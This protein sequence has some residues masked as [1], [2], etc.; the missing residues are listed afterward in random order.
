M[1]A[2]RINP[3][4][5]SSIATGL[6]PTAK[7]A[8][9]AVSGFL[10]SM[11]Q[12]RQEEME[13]ERQ[14]QKLLTLNAYERG[15]SNVD[16]T[17]EQ[18]AD[19][20]SGMLQ[21]GTEQKIDF[22][23]EDISDLRTRSKETRESLTEEKER[24]NVIKAA[25]AAATKQK[26]SK[27][28]IDIITSSRKNAQKF[29]DNNRVFKATEYTTEIKKEIKNGKLKHILRYIP[30]DP[31]K[32]PIERELGEAFD[33][34]FAENMAENKNLLG[35][36]FGEQHQTKQLTELN[37][38]ISSSEASLNTANEAVLR[39]QNIG[40]LGRYTPNM[41]LHSLAG[42]FGMAD[43]DTTQLIAAAKELQTVTALDLLPVGPASDKDI[44]LVMDTTVDILKLSAEQ[45]TM[46]LR[47]IAKIKQ[48][49]LDK[50][51]AK[52]QYM[53]KYQDHTA[54]GFDIQYEHAMA[55]K[56]IAN[57][58]TN[59]S[60]PYNNIQN[61]LKEIREAKKSGNQQEV[62]RLSK[63]LE[64]TLTPYA[65]PSK[66]TEEQLLA[67]QLNI[68]IYNA[69]LSKGRANQKISNLNS[70]DQKRKVRIYE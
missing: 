28:D 13:K 27:E 51:K 57:L 48:A 64:V 11:K 65:D 21:L 4:L 38:L 66:H 29:L 10:P 60:K 26:L 41:F 15:L 6:D 67:K 8:A 32:E 14:R 39:S 5:L 36:G 34:D 16:T 43:A 42:A 53:Q 24:E 19:V 35:E 37:D 33:E 59:H 56:R 22:T 31:N 52:K 44:A 40:T 30:N 68:D 3:G 17:A 58:E 50:L 46:Y 7:M 45:R 47:G 55:E 25:K 23:P 12:A 2:T 18:R 69:I 54:S 1:S 63:I 62:V 49:Q 61:Q 20:L 9:Q 70:K